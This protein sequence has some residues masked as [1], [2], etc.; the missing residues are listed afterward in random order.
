MKSSLSK[1]RNTKKIDYILLFTIFLLIGVGLVSVY[2][3]LSL[4]HTSGNF[5]KQQLIWLII[6]MFAVAV[7]LYLGNDAIFEMAYI[8]YWILLGML[9]ILALVHIGSRFTSFFSTNSFFNR[10]LHETNGAHSWFYLPIGSFQPSEFMKIIMLLITADI[11]QNHN[12]LKV[13]DSFMS[14]VK[15]LLDILKW[16]VPPALLTLVQPDTGMFLIYAVSIFIMFCCAGIRKEWIVL[17]FGFLAIAVGIFLFVYI[18]YIRTGVINL[19]G[20]KLDRIEAWLYPESNIDGV[21]YQAYRAQISMGAAGLNGVG[22]QE[23]LLYF[24]EPQTDMIF[25]VLGQSFGF[26]GSVFAVILYAILDL[27]TAY[28]AYSTDNIRDKYFITG[29]LGLLLFQ[30]IWNI[31][32]VIGLLPITGITLPFL[33]YGGSSLLS[34]MII[35]AIVFNT[36]LMRDTQYHG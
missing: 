36:S 3:S 33:S 15:L 8:I 9:L 22:L 2:S 24:P 30:Q 7:I 10:F 25:A 26:I 5:I 20:Y 21:A 12:R 13:E 17:I 27:R 35:F 11:I 14:D 4:V 31:G 32:M 18:N 1:V 29:V 28:I 6:S 34:Y 23:V 16:V 19:G